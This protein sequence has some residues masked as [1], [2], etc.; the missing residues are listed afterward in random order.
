MERKPK[1]KYV[2]KTIRAT[3]F[4]KGSQQSIGEQKKEEFS[5][6]FQ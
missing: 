5:K 4:N 1:S 3:T 6:I 2:R